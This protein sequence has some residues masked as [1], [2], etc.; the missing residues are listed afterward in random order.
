MK[1]IVLE[2][3]RRVDREKKQWAELYGGM[4]D[5]PLAV[6]A[7]RDVHAWE[8]LLNQAQKVWR[9]PDVIYG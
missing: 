5:D 9:Q 6:A 4:P 7:Y 3:Q 8:T 1:Q 2:I